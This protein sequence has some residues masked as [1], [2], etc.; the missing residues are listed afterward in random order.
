[1]K[2]REKNFQ[3]FLVCFDESL[4]VKA[5]HEVVIANGDNL[6]FVSS[7]ELQL[8]DLILMNV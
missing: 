4:G 6:L 5:V 8:G 2:S 1:M 7:H 3:I